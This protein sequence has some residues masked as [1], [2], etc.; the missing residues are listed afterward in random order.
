MALTRVG[1]NTSAVNFAR[2]RPIIT[3]NAAI[4]V[5][6]GSSVTG[7]SKFGVRLFT[8]SLDADQTAVAAG[9][10]QQADSP[11]Y[12]AAIQPQLR[13]GLSGDST[14]STEFMVSLILERFMNAILLLWVF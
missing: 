6:M 9:T 3:A 11:R 13:I 12:A 14:A 7:G 8:A 4:N 1:K 5:A 10:T 2:G